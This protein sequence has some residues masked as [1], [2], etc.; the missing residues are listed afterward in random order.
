MATYIRS[1]FLCFLC[2]GA[3]AQGVKADTFYYG[4]V[5]I[6][7]N[8]PTAGSLLFEWDR[9]GGDWVSFQTA[10]D[11]NFEVG[12][13][14]SFLIDD[15]DVPGNS[16]A[17]SVLFRFKTGTY[18]VA[19]TTG[20]GYTLNTTENWPNQP[21]NGVYST[22]TWSYNAF[23][24]ETCARTVTL[25]NESLR[26]QRGYWSL[27]D[28]VIYSEDIPPGG[29]ATH[30]ITPTD[31]AGVYSIKAWTVT[32]ML[33]EDFE[34]VPTTNVW[35]TVTDTTDTGHSTTNS[36]AVVYTPPAQIDADEAVSGSIAPVVWSAAS[37]TN[38][39]RATQEG[40]SSLI[41][42]QQQFDSAA[43]ELL[44]AI[45][46]NTAPLAGT[47]MEISEMQAQQGAANSSSNY[48]KGI[49]FGM[50]TT[51]NPVAPSMLV[52]VAG[53]SIDLDPL[54]NTSIANGLAAV[55]TILL[56]AIGAWCVFKWSGFGQEAIYAMLR[57]PQGSSASGVPVVGSASALTMAIAVADLIAVVPDFDSH[58]DY[59][60]AV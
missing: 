56:W 1:W 35:D 6:V 3:F 55:R 44:A 52:S 34:L 59:F 15:V 4:T 58:A 33:N 39:S 29:S 17:Q 14:R 12:E 19:P 49:G 57:A 53:H 48:L 31:C 42:S 7:N 60:A 40:F 8:G 25:S 27:N 22:Y 36:V 10:T 43:L 50:T 54:H 21:Q 2:L 26:M 37:G 23:T 28:V 38:S 13:S 18:G 51:I 41:L 32:L 24:V 11:N 5:T 9:D 20:S 47:P 16:A 46:T 45:R 30:T